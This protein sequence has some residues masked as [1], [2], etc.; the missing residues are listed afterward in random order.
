MAV[1]LSLDDFY[2]DLSGMSAEERARVNFDEPA[3]IDWECVRAVL[4][5]LSDGAT[6]AVPNYDFART[7]AS[8][9]G[10]RSSVMNSSFGT[11][12]GCCMNSGCENN[13]P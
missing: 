12:S 2:R 4:R 11:D 5:A 6:A 10:D 3:A 13:S 1:R 7:R 9:S 8:A